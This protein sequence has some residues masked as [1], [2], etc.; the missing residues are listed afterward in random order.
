MGTS[1]TGGAEL[2]APPPL[3]SGFLRLQAP[4]GCTLGVCG[5]LVLTLLGSLGLEAQPPLLG[6]T[7]SIVLCF[8]LFC[9][10]QVTYL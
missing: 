7:T 8:Q 6:V 10:V 2:Q 3:L 9:M 5:W 1:T 4:L